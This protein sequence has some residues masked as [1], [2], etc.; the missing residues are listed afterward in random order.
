[1]TPSVLPGAAEA[2]RI[3]VSASTTAGAVRRS[4]SLGRIVGYYAALA[5]A[6]FLLLRYVP[7]VSEALEG[8]AAF[9]VPDAGGVFGPDAPPA[10]GTMVG[11]GSPWHQAL[12]ATVS[13]LGALAVMAPVTW[14][15]MLTRRRR[16]YDASVVHAL[17]ILP[18]AVTGIIM[19]VKSSVTLAFSLAGV[20]AAVRFRTA[21]DDTLDAVYVFLA[22][23][24]GIASGIQALGVA[25]ALSL[26]FNL[27]VLVLW[28]T[29][30]GNIYAGHATALGIGDVLAG[31]GSGVS[32]LRVGDPAVLEAARPADV[33][34]LADRAVRIE[35][36]I[37]EERG[38]KKDKRANALILVHAKAAEG[39][40]AYVDKLLEEKAARWKLAEIGSGPSGVL[41]VYLARFE[42]EGVQGAV[43]DR[44][45]SGAMGVVEA[46]EL[47]S[48][49]GIKPRE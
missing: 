11:P 27:V 8:G 34:D 36:H 16:G 39:A 9:G 4:G 37:S 42:G 31:P 32:A 19:V 33:A 40:Q 25:V 47:R 5:V 7:L 6:G 12:L 1:M 13:M 18:V 20:V 38:K 3:L 10:V 30:F 28:Q 49:K 29:R 23:G 24:I 21:L 22:I 17:L 45:R 41:L 48:L 2:L 44:L 43:M 26:V 15:Y 46:A 35:R 14:V